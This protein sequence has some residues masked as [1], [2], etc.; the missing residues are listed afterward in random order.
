MAMT[1]MSPRMSRLLFASTSLTV[2]TGSALAADLPIAKA[3]PP[4]I[5]ASWAGFYF[6]VHGGYGWKRDDFSVSDGFLFRTPQHINGIRSQGAV[7]GGQ[8]G[9]NWQFGRAVTGLEI[10]FSAGDI[11]GSNAISETLAPPAASNVISM[12]E[13]VKYLGSARARLGWEPTDNVLL[14]GTAGLAWE[15]M[16]AT[17][18]NTRTIGGN[19][20]QFSDAINRTALDKFGWVAGAGVEV[21]LGSPNWIGRLEYLH[22]EMRQVQQ[23]SSFAQLG[24]LSDVST[25]GSQTIDVVRAGVSYKFGEPAPNVAVPY[26]K[27]P[28][29]AAPHANWAGFYLGGHGGY[30]WGDD[31]VTIPAPF[32]EQID[33]GSISGFKT[34][35]W[36]VGGQVGHNWQY[37]RFV[38]GLEADF[39]AADIKGNSSTLVTPFGNGAFA[40]DQFNEKVKYLGTVRG[41]LGWLPTDNVLL[42]GTAGLAW[43][44]LERSTRNVV[45]DATGISTSTVAVPSSRFGWVAGVGGE[46]M[47]GSPNWI[48][49]IEYL[50]YDFGRTFDDGSFTFTQLGV[51][52]SGATIRAGSQTIDVVRAGVSYKFGPDGPLAATPAMSTKAPRAAPQLASWT[53]FYIG[54]H[55]GYGWKDNDYLTGFFDVYS[56]GIK[57]Q[58]WLGG[59]Q[60]GYN[61][62]YTNVVGGVEIDGSATGIKGS[63]PRVVERT[64]TFSITDSDDVKYLGTV[65]GRLGWTPAATWLLYGTGGLAWESANRTSLTTGALAPPITAVAEVPRD[66]FGWAAGVGVETFIGGPNWVARLEYLHY[67]FG[68]VEPVTITATPQAGDPNRTDRGGRQTIDTVRAAVSYKF[69]P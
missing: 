59:G 51:P 48:G 56:G 2:L 34:S 4:A 24:G 50:H 36:I 25:A 27:V 14:Y 67:D 6:G 12:S 21:M 46:V 20:Q 1:M 69:T 60:A 17:Q 62:Q 33:S 65:R 23:A 16:D 26:A 5:A 47:L 41:R 11:K 54:A 63:A 9:Y 3:P 45:T 52:S 18:H 42:Y 40:T 61:W 22:Y 13:G 44:R 37:E 10:D 7:Y 68:S 29:I 28:A 49:R 30:G 32:F 55:G 66:H 19:I 57:S 15:R 8:A 53:G 38:T 58:G 39:S 31:P 35:G 43:E 64:G